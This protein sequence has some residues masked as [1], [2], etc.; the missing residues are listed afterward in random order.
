MFYNVVAPEVARSYQGPPASFGLPKQLLDRNNPDPERMVP[1]IVDGFDKLKERHEA[2][3]R[4]RDML[5]EQAAVR[6]PGTLA[7]VLRLT[8]AAGAGTGQD[9][10]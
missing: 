10:P 7:G 6:A 5:M 9:C 4:T 2:Q 3:L 1:V 8:A